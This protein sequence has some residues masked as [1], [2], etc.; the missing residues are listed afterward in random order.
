M[1]EATKRSIQN[2]NS[3]LLDARANVNS[4]AVVAETIKD[5][6]L[7]DKLAA[8]AASVKDTSDYIKSR[9]GEGA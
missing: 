6:V 2:I 9:A 1:S 8:T 5:K 7:A 3:Y 4:A